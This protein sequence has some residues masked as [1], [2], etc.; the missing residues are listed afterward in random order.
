MKKKS[1]N[2][3]VENCIP[4]LSSCIDW[5]GGDID[6]LGICDGDKLNNIV[7]EIVS[8]LQDIVTDDLSDFDIDSALNICKQVA[9]LQVDLISILNI[10]KNNDICLNDYITTLQQEVANLS[11]QTGV[12]VDLKC[13]ADFDNLGNALSVTRDTLDQLV[14]NNLCSQQSRITSLEGAVTDMQ[15]QINNLEINPVVDELSF[16]TCIDAAVLPTSTQVIN[17]ANELCSLETALGDAGDITTALANTPGD[18]NSEF[19]TITGWVNVP[20]NFMQNY[21]NLLLE[22][23]NLRQ[24]IK[25]IENTCCASSCDDVKL[26]FSVIWNEDGTGIIIK[27]TSGSGT[28]IPAGF[29]DKGSTG[30]ITDVDG[31]VQDFT[32]AITNNLEQEVSVVGL[33]MSGSLEL[34]ITAILGTDSLTCEKCLHKTISTTGACS[35]CEICVTGSTG[36]VTIV[37][38]DAG[39][40]IATSFD[41]GT[42]T[43][44]STTT[45]TTL[46]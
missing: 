37:Y 36:T 28:S 20:A 4:T 45:T 6:F 12:N 13:F 22:L 43:T 8:K 34:N 26:G 15:S 31:N 33:N 24:R 46:A 29:T 42:T 25:T 39:S 40:F 14:I 9:P 38:E 5:N 32:L 10:L 7:I 3:E 23:E 21:G 17:T 35:Y 2:C 44:T 1:G 19:G 27:F 16:A 41:P 18:L 11:Q 30:T